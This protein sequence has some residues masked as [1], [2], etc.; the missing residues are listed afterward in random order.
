MNT[1]VANENE[2]DQVDEVNKYT[3]KIKNFISI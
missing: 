1:A 2:M 3:E